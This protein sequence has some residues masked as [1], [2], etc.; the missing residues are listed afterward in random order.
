MQ[1]EVR[2]PSLG[3][4]R[5]AV[6]GGIVSYWLADEGVLLEEGD[7]LIELTTDKAAF[8]MP[9]PMSGILLEK[10]VDEGDEVSVG[11]VLCIVEIADEE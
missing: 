1:Y 5:D 7:D 9:C 8:V 2:L 4:E 11:N 10:R 3:E 6:T